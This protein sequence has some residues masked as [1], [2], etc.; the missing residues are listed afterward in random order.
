MDVDI[1]QL[2]VTQNHALHRFEVPLGDKF[3]LIDYSLRDS[4]YVLPHAEVPPEYGGRGI[5]SEMTRQTLDMIRAEGKGVWASP[6]CPF[7]RSFIQKNQVYQD[8]VIQKT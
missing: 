1:Q 3:G 7:V 5:A 6:M 2:Q 8:M 4:S